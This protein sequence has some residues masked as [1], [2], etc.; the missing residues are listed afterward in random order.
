MIPDDPGISVTEVT[1][2]SP[3]HG[4]SLAYPLMV[5]SSSGPSNPTKSRPLP[6]IPI[7]EFLLPDFDITPCCMQTTE[8]ILAS[9]SIMEFNT[10]F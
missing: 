7:L 8:F 6:Q 3:C 10:H 5:T 4:L 9:F 1:Y 2:V